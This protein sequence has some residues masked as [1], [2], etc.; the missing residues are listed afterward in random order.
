[1]VRAYEQ[2]KREQRVEHGTDVH[3]RAREQR[4]G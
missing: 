1:M 3:E 4:V 2:R